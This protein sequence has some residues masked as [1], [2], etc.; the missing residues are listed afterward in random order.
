MFEII[1]HWSQFEHSQQCQEQ[2]PVVSP[3]NLELKV[4]VLQDQQ[5][6]QACNQHKPQFI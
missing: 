6:L 4:F 2:G 1:L 5:H 3:D